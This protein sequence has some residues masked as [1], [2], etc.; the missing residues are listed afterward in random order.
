[1]DIELQPL[2]L[3]TSNLPPLELVPTCQFPPQLNRATSPPQQRRTR[4]SSRADVSRH[5]HDISSNAEESSHDHGAPAAAVNPT[6]AASP[7]DLPCRINSFQA[8]LPGVLPSANFAS[9]GG[10]ASGSAYVV[11]KQVH[12]NP[13]RGF[14]SQIL[15]HKAE[16]R[17][18]NAG[19]EVSPTFT[20]P[21]DVT[22]KPLSPS[23]SPRYRMGRSSYEEAI[24]ILKKLSAF[25]SLSPAV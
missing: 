6:P 8:A 16:A 9:T 21:D 24:S 1:M 11:D 10:A 15:F 22:E 5:V 2:E 17:G 7:T 14:V 18:M 23:E 12:P 4:R 25:S 19:S 13:R 20:S 3:A